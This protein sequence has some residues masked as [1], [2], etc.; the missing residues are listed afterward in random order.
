MDNYTTKVILFAKLLK[1]EYPDTV[2]V[3]KKENCNYRVILDDVFINVPID[4]IWVNFKKRVHNILNN[5]I[6]Q[7]CNICMEKKD[8]YL[9]CLKCPQAYCIECFLNIILPSRGVIKCPFCRAEYGEE[10]SGWDLKEFLIVMC[11]NFSLDVNTLM[12]SN[13]YFKAIWVLFN[14]QRSNRDIYEDWNSNYMRD[15]RDN[16]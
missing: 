6:T 1:K 16:Q 2:I 9:T 14:T 4:A 5:V 3:I 11:K 12:E 13:P 8:T 7:E 15:L 10:M